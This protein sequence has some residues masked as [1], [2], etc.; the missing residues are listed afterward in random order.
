[1]QFRNED[2]SYI[3]RQPTSPPMGRD[4]SCSGNLP[5]T[6]EPEF[7]GVDAEFGVEPFQQADELGVLVL[8]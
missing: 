5:A 2:L 6:G 7:C 1:M 8:D 3:K 4:F